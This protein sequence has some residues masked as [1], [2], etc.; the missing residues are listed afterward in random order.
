MLS[1]RQVSR[2]RMSASQFAAARQAYRDL[3]YPGGLPSTGADQIAASG[4]T[5]P[6]CSSVTR[7]TFDRPGGRDGD[8]Q[9]AY[10]LTPTATPVGTT[11]VWMSGHGYAYTGIYDQTDGSSPIHVALTRGWHVVLCPLPTTE[12]DSIIDFYESAGHTSIEYLGALQTFA[13]HSW[14]QID[15][16]DSPP[17]AA[18]LFTDKI[19]R[20]TNQAVATLAPSRLILSGHSGGATTSTWVAALDDRFSAHY[21]HIPGLP[22]KIKPDTPTGQMSD[23]EQCTAL[24]PVYTRGPLAS[25]TYWTFLLGAATPGRR[26]GIVAALNDPSWTSLTATTTPTWLDVVGEIEE[27]VCAVP[28]A[29]ATHLLQT[30]GHDMNIDRVNWMFNDIEVYS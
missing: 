17:L 1:P 24:N 18:R 25:D 27:Y 8:S 11:L 16:N 5:V 15:I 26:S 28:G 14:S 29:S 12:W 10:L 9:N 21:C 23:W 2:W 13:G 3:I 20:A 22:Q 19:L 6:A 4:Y 30:T 7:W